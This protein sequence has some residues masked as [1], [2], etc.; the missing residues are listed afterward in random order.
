LFLKQWTLNKTI[1]MGLAGDKMSLGGP[2]LGGILALGYGGL[3]GGFDQYFALVGGS[4]IPLFLDTLTQQDKVVRA[5]TETFN[6]A[7]WTFKDS[8]QSFLPWD[9]LLWAHRIDSQV[10]MVNACN[11]EF[12]DPKNTVLNFQEVL[13]ENGQSVSSRWTFWGHNPANGSLASLYF[14]FIYPLGRF[15]QGQPVVSQSF[16]KKCH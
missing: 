10:F 5:I 12:L 4:N 3:V 2:S 7:D 11:D 15:A 6:S 16:H 8:I 14:N 9:P 13:K 1:P